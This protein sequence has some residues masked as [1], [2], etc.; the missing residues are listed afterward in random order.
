M[1]AEPISVRVPFVWKTGDNRDAPFKKVV[2]SNLERIL[3]VAHV[4]R[5][6]TCFVSRSHFLRDRRFFLYVLEISERRISRKKI[7]GFASARWKH[8]ASVVARAFE[9]FLNARD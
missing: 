4:D 6:S 3:V 1:D 8:L 9:S 5:L 7:Y 2:F